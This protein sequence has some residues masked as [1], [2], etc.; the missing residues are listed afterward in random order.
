[1]IA[2]LARGGRV[3]EAPEYTEA[4]RRAAEFILARLRRPDNRLY[5]RY[6]DGEAAIAG[7]AND[8][9]FLIFGLIEL[10]QSC[11]DPSF[12]EAAIGLQEIMNADCWDE[13]RGGFFLTPAG[14][15]ELFVRPKELY[16]GAI[17]SANSIALLNLLTLAR[18]TGHPRWEAAA[19]RQVKA[20]AGNIAHQPLLYTAFLLGVDFALGTGQE[21]EKLPAPP[22]RLDSRSDTR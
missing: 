14:G 20:F 19:E 3:L 21:I 4:A 17:P 2:A 18:L 8:Y 16:D 10:Y 11:F 9:A 22:A 15:D 7:M 5:H 1:M 13:K 6:R 12:L